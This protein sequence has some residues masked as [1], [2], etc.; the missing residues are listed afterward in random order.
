M[1]NSY[2]EKIKNC[3]NFTNSFFAEDQEALK[4]DY[5]DKLAKVLELTV[6]LIKKYDTAKTHKFY[7]Q[8]ESNHYLYVILLMN[9]EGEAKWQIDSSSNPKSF[10]E[11][12]TTEELVNCCW[13]NLVNIQNF[14][15]KIFEYLTQ[16]IEKKESYIKQKK[17]KYNSEINC[18]NEAIENLQ[19]LIDTDIPEEIRNK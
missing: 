17:N 2:V 19:E 1:F 14:I 10:E 5:C 18:L 4:K 3:I 16:M 13:R 12:L 6:N 7:F 8:A 11:S 15:T 9:N